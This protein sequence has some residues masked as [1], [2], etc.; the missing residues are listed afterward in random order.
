MATTMFHSPAVELARTHSGDGAL[1]IRMRDRFVDALLRPIDRV[2]HFIGARYS[3]FFWIVD[4][5][6]PRLL[7]WLGDL[8]ARRAVRYAV[9]RVPAY[10]AHVGAGEGPPADV[11][12]LIVPE[13]DKVGYVKAH[14]LPSRC[15]GGE[16]PGHR[17]VIDESSGST[18]QPF[19]WVRTPEERLA[20]HVFI[21]HFARY[22]YG[23]GPFITINAF[24]MGAWATGLNMGA[25]MERTTVV[26][27]TGP[28]ID[29][30][31]ATLEF[32]GPTRQFLICGYPPF[33]KALVDE[34]D[35]RHFPLHE[36]H[37]DGLVG[38]EGMSEGLRDYLMGPRRFRRVF[39][40]FG[41]T[42]IEIGLA[43]ET[44]VCVALRRLAR[45]NSEVRR[46]LFGDDPRLPMV[47]QYNPL[48]HHV[49][50]ND[51]GE[52]IFTINRLDVLAPRIAYNVHDKGGVATFADVMDVLTRHGIDPSDLTGS[53]AAVPLPFL[54]VH[55][56]SDATIS[57][58]G[59]NIYPEDLEQAL[60]DHPDVA[61]AVTSYLLRSR[62]QS[63]GTIRPELAFATEH[64]SAE[65]QERI[66]KTVVPSMVALNADLRTAMREHA[67]SVRPIVSLH[68]PGTGPFAADSGKIK[69]TRLVV[70]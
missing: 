27:S 35:R 61:H 36:Y 47:F 39:S 49:A 7:A 38:G 14:P 31:L 11:A 48:Q 59:A 63:D 64:A 70:G 21:S 24:S 30:I 10:A 9:R 23:D 41:A 42:D 19:N 60:Y 2:L 4:H 56:R 34:A 25:A 53:E 18:G 32:L 52:L 44:P 51:T 8:R 46:A 50:A 29:K 28:D 57:V 20:T 58:M 68:A 12:G 1:R 22:D 5:T 17:V 37:L 15:I 65:L 54:W 55:G 45:D 6:P 43:G 3:L 66:E 40:G 67:D 33:L 69:Q 26:K 62:E 16:L 13:T